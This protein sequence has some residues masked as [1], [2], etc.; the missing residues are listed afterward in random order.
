[1]VSS[2]ANSLGYGSGLDVAKLV[3]DLAAASRDPKVARFDTQARANQTSIS[4]VGQARSDLESFS[5]SLASLVAGGTLRSQPTVSD[6]SVLE[7]KAR[8]GVRLGDLSGEVEVVQLARGQSTV[9][10]YAAAASDPVGRGTLTLTVGAMSYAVPIGDANDSLNGMAKAINDTKSGVTASVITDTSG[11]RLLLKG[12]TGAASAYSVTTTDTALS[13]FAYPGGMTALQNAQ[14][15]AIKVD[16]L[17]YSRASNT[18]DDVLPGVILSLK[19]AAVGSVVSIGV[20]PA[21]EALKSTIGDFVSVFNTLKGHIADARTATHGDNAMRNLDLQLS[22]IVAQPVTSGLP[23]SLSAIGVK[24]N[25]DGT[26][27]FDEDVFKAAY[28]ADPGSVEAIFSPLRDATHDTTTDPGIGGALTALKTAAT[29]TSGL[30]TGLSA[31]LSRETKGIADDRARM[32]TR[33]TAY[34]AR[35]D[36]QFG[37]LDGHVGA[38][39][40]T[41]SYLDQQIKVWTASR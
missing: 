6:T 29:A 17:P 35:L 36:K 12:A 18:I 13:G 2:I 3:T 11:A 7:A 22:R 15:A 19:R 20:S 8:P 34:K 26:L 27:A 1:M 28:S 39:K 9:S 40:A 5:S 23:A 25:R 37:G 33:E 21:S 41:Q 16:G 38:L 10:A 30:L 4:A 32:E 24:T 14:D 31:R